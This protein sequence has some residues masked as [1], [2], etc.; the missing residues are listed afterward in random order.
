MKLML[1]KL[2]KNMPFN[3][4]LI[5]HLPAYIK[6]VKAERRIR[7]AGLIVFICALA[8]QIFITL[9]PAQPTLTS[10]PN[11]LIRGGFKSQLEAVTDCTNNVQGYKTILAR[12]SIT[13]SDISSATTTQ[14]KSTAFGDQLYTL[15]RLGY[16]QN[17]EV[18][19][20]IN[21][22]TY[23]FRPLNVWNKFGSSSFTVLSGR[24]QTGSTFELLYSSGNLALA[25]KPTPSQNIC[26]SVSSAACA[27]LSV[28]VRN[29][30]QSITA[31]NGSLAKPGDQIVY[32]LV[33]TN[34]TS[35]TLNN[36][37]FKL[38]VSSSL[39]YAKLTNTYGGTINDGSVTWPSTSLKP[40]QTKIE[41]AVFSVDSPI[42][43]T[44]ASSTDPGYYN[45]EMTTVYGN[46][47]LIKTPQ[48]FS[49]FVE[50]NINNSLASESSTTSLITV[51]V[52]GLVMLYFVLRNNL[53][54][55]E[56]YGL[57]DDYLDDRERK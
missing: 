53:L 14:I 10:S 54:L 45:S 46:S 17:S 13:C 38:N 47:L 6:T 25:G 42:P 57:K 40:S 56:L 19:T 33:A 4:S 24:S 3:P 5:E 36:F 22:Q 11:D 23:W 37:V 29:D 12:F 9:S 8:V 1:K 20:V 55:T 7:V 32:T 2:L 39:T 49:K 50:I 35:S 34:P 15:N 31:A 18:Q 21:G 48:S 43:N 41:Q 26:N 52:I 44:P 30:T 27:N 51:V 16:G 28:T